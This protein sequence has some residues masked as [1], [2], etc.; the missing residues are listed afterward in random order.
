MVFEHLFPEALLE[1]RAWAAFVLAAVYSTLAIIISRL[2]F[3]ANS[4]IVSV[5]FVSIFLL[6]YFSTLLKRE[7]LQELNEKRPE[8]WQLL[9]DN[10]DMIRIYVALFLGIYFTY[11]VYTFLGPFFGYDVGSVFREQLSLEG[12]R[13]GASFSFMTFADI[14][15]NNWWVLLATF[16]I[17]LVAGDGAVFFIAWNASA[18]GTIFGY[19][20]IA[21][22]AFD[23]SSALVALIIIVAITLPHLLL[24][25]GAY[26]LAAIAGGVISDEVDDPVEVRRFVLYFLVLALGY[27]VMYMML[28]LLLSD[29]SGA[30]VHPFLL[31]LLAMALALGGLYCMHYLFTG[32]RDRVV[33]RYNC[34]L[35][36]LAIGIFI[37]GAIVETFVLHNSGLLRGVYMAAMMGG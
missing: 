28:R 1:R 17:A 14:V 2:L 3:P 29:R 31:G 35:F 15:L 24:E 4:G 23:G 33:F 34:Y 13:G 11:M 21:A 5:V 18:W 37:V 26:L 30:L 32:A 36:A 8:F 22:S 12:I 10:A 27:A 25:G 9:K 20:A 16:L 19:R 6:P 7:E